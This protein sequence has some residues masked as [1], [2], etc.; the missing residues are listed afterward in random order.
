MCTLTIDP[1]WPGLS[2]EKHTGVQT[3]QLCVQAGRPCIQ[4]GYKYIQARNQVFR[5]DSFFGMILRQIPTI[6]ILLVLIPLNSIINFQNF[7]FGLLSSLI[8]NA[9]KFG[10]SD[11]MEQLVGWYEQHGKL[12]T[13][14]TISDDADTPWH[15]K[16]ILVKER[17]KAQNY[18]SN[19][20]MRSKRNSV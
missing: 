16:D 14:K 7:K 19:T 15:I 2:T 1:S 10:R 3:G 5:L 6:G 18:I 13:L 8:S 12:R 17:S 4:A 11:E 20:R 9:N